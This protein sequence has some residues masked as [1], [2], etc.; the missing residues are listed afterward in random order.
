MPCIIIIH[1]PRNYDIIEYLRKM[2]R[3]PGY[4]RNYKVPW[5]HSYI[6]ISNAHFRQWMMLADILNWTTLG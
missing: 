2:R 4:T 1:D 3:C 5:I 6:R